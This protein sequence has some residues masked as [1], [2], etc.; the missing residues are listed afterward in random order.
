MATT[1]EKKVEQ[2]QLQEQSLTPSERS[3]IKTKFDK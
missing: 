2:L 3:R 1:L